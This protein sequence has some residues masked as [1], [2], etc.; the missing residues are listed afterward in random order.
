MKYVDLHLSQPTEMLH[1]MQ[2]FAREESVVRYEELLAYTGVGGDREIEYL[3][4][5]VESPLEPYESELERVESIRWYDV[6][7]AGDDSFYLYVCQ[8]TRAADRDWRSAF[9]DRNLVAVPPIRYD[10]DGSFHVTVVGVTED[11][12]QLL[13]SL[14]DEIEVEVEAVGEYADKHEPITGALTARQRTAVEAAVAAGFYSY[15][16]EAGVEAV[17]DRLDVAASTATE[18]LQKAEAKLMQTITS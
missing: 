2:A 1:P 17:A 14:P 7:P 5:Y 4:M 15:P 8:E 9:V 18:L 11:L 12:R 10:S 16:R 6:T 3:L 13:E